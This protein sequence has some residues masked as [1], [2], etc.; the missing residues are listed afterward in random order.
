[1]NRE[2]TKAVAVRLGKTILKRIEGLER[3]YAS[4]ERAEQVGPVTRS[5]ILRLAILRGLEYL[6]RPGPRRLSA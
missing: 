2:P 4:G 6:E 1:M 3:A 5:G